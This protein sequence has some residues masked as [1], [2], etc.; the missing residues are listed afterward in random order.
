MI[1]LHKLAYLE[2]T[3]SCHLMH[4]KLVNKNQKSIWSGQV[5]GCPPSWCFQH[6]IILTHYKKMWFKRWTIFFNINKKR[7]L[8][9]CVCQCERVAKTTLILMLTPLHN[10]HST[11]HNAQCTIHNAHCTMPMHTA[12]CTIH[13][14]QYT[15]HNVVQYTIHNVQWTIHNAHCTMHNAVH[16]HLIKALEC[17]CTS[18]GDH[19]QILNQIF[20]LES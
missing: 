11:M 19:F 18:S 12:Q 20:P 17:H 15:I 5:V 13:N 1:C 14:V 8:V 7:S 3:V 16:I 6:E 10:A 9:V 2:L 4:E